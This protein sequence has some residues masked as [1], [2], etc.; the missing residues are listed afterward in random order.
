MRFLALLLSA[1]VCGCT[2]SPLKVHMLSG[3]EE[4][5][6]ED[7][8]KKWAGHLENKFGIEPTFSLGTDRITTV[9]GLDHLAD[10]DVLAS[11]S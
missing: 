5:K 2:A 11:P 3:S 6:S 9:G 10:A 4:Y 8:L 7:S 1:V